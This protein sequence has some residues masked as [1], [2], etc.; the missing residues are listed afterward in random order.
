MEGN[1]TG[2]AGG[3]VE[4]LV[5]RE[6]ERYCPGPPLTVQRQ[7]GLYNAPYDVCPSQHYRFTCVLCI[8]VINTPL[9]FAELLVS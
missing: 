9:L 6:G 1:K 4:G 2:R 5:E 7:T 3:L 8:P